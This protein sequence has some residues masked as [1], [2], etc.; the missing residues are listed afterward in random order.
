MLPPLARRFL[1]SAV[2]L[3]AGLLLSGCSGLYHANATVGP[4]MQPHLTTG[5]SIPFGK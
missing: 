5:V 3:L 4:D 1:L 2:L